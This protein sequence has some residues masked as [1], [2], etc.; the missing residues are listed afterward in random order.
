MGLYLPPQ[1]KASSSFYKSSMGKPMD[2]HLW[3]RVKVGSHAGVREHI[4]AQENACVHSMKVEKKKG[5]KTAGH[6]AAPFH[7]FASPFFFTRTFCER[8][9]LF[10][11]TK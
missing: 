9:Y 2:W 11:V 8:V 7:Y 3:L 10:H 5:G 4:G 1:P 6:A